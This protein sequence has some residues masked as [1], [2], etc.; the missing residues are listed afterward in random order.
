M[1]KGCFTNFK[2]IIKPD[3]YYILCFKD[4][5]KL[6]L[7]R[8]RFK[9]KKAAIYY[10][11]KFL[12]PQTYEPIKGKYA[13][14]LG[15]P[16]RVKRERKRPTRYDY[17]DNWSTGKMMKKWFRNW[18]RRIIRRSMRNITP[19]QQYTLK[20]KDPIN[21]KKFIL[22]TLYTNSIYSAFRN[23]KKHLGIKKEVFKI[24]ISIGV[25]ETNN[26]EVRILPT[27]INKTRI[28]V[29]KKNHT[30]ILKPNNPGS[31]K[32]ISKLEIELLSS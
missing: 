1:A 22:Y 3:S 4:L 7:V 28:N 24:N 30:R 11:H 32:T 18:Q 13:L 19:L 31:S 6:Q 29:F 8:L 10:I 23:F 15:I 16:I 20:L 9:N 14:K 5:R 17:P 25:I 26:K 21:S 2:R 27:I 12:T